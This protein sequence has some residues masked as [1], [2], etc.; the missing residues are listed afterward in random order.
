MT[1]NA[2]PEDRSLAPGNSGDAPAAEGRSFDHWAAEMAEPKEVDQFAESDVDSL[3]LD[4]DEPVAA[5][6]EETATGLRGH[7]LRFVADLVQMAADR[8]A[9]EARLEADYQAAV[10]AAAQAT[11]VARQDFAAWLQTEEREIG[12]QRVAARQTADQR[13][14]S[15]TTPRTSVGLPT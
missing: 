7:E 10:E 13:A 9:A 4:A 5:A 15:A 3:S 11:E 8:V 12:T 6:A 2:D 1:A 14:T